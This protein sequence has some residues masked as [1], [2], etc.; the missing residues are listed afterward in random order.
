MVFSL[1]CGLVGA[2]DGDQP[3]VCTVRTLCCCSTGGV[4]CAV[5]MMLLGLLYGLCGPNDAV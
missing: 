1:L 4:E 5:L 3:A 2:T